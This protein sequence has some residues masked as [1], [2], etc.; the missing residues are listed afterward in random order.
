MDLD[1]ISLNITNLRRGMWERLTKQCA[2]EIRRTK[3]SRGE[4]LYFYFSLHQC[5]RKFYNM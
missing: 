5:Q 2:S 3:Q 4:Q 1:R